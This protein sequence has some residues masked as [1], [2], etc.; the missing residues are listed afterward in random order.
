[1]ARSTRTRMAFGH[2]NP[3]TIEK[4]GEFDWHAWRHEPHGDVWLGFF[5]DDVTALEWAK[6]QPYD[7]TINNVPPPTSHHYI[8]GDYTWGSFTKKGGD[9]IPKV[10]MPPRHRVSSQPQR[11]TAKPVQKTR[12][13][14]QSRPV[15]VK[16]TA[17][18]KR[19]RKTAKAVL[20]QHKRDE[21]ADIESGRTQSA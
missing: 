6:K 9:G 12:P 5:K 8:T 10:V 21:Q 16:E 20:D 17:D 14:Q 4:P 2:P 19:M 1:M 18:Q 15:A 11:V 13:V 7:I 3:I